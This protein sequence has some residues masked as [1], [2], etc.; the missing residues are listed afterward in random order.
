MHSSYVPLSLALI[1]SGIPFIASEHSVPE[2]YKNKKMEYILLILA[3]LRAHK[4]T[5][6]S[7]TI[8]AR[9]PRRVSRRMVPVPNPVPSPI[10]KND[11]N[12]KRP[13]S[14]Y[15]LTVGRMDEA[16]DHATLIRAFALVQ[17]K[18]D[19]VRLRIVGDGPLA[20][21]LKR[22]V[23]DLALEGYV[24]MPGRLAEVGPE[25]ANAQLFVLPSKYES[26]GIVATEA[27]SYGLPVIAF[28]DCPG[29]NEIIEH[30]VNGLLVQGKPKVYALTE[31]L[32][33]LLSDPK[34]ALRLGAEGPPS[35]SR[36][37]IHRVLS[38][39]EKLLCSIGR[40]D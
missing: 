33:D 37:N 23:R 17:S 5:A 6:L 25:Y 21:N 27:L 20:G 29:V 24:E 18:F 1:G 26:F 36:F 34:K 3:C 28:A 22:L 4:V 12:A 10:R 15:V 19:D 39:W 38:H 16:K 32:S 11:E 30:D 31:A 40:A 13:C 2:Y 8:I 35:V 9:Y 7:N 14:H